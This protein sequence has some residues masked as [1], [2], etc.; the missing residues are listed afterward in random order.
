LEEVVPPCVPS[1]ELVPVVDELLEGSV[2]LDVAPVWVP[3]VELDDDGS[4][5][6]VPL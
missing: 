6:V 3:S 4:V 1:V 2:E 5:V